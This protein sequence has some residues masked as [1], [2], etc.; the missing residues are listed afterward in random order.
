MNQPFTAFST[1]HVTSNQ[2]HPP[3]SVFDGPGL[4]G[5]EVDGPGAEEVADG[6]GEFGVV[7]GEPVGAGAG[8]VGAGVGLGEAGGCGLGLAAAITGPAAGSASARGGEPATAT[9]A[10]AAAK[11]ASTILLQVR[12]W[13]GIRLTRPR[14]L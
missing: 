7:V 12:E 14:S 8:A 11:P 13:V 6:D 3:V 9:A 10:I 2:P 5:G 1:R 4:A